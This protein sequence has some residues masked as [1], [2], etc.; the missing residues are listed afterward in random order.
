MDR[1]LL[2]T[3]AVQIHEPV[4]R[5]GRWVA[6]IKPG[7][8]VY[9][10]NTDGSRKGNAATGGGVLRDSEGDFILGFTTHFKHSDAL[11]AEL[12]V[13]GGVGYYTPGTSNLCF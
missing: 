2:E 4:F 11:R 5:R 8:N 1:I 6:W 10:L 9:K 13:T 3:L 12:G 7:S